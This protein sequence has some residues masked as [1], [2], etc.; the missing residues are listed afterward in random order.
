MSSNKKA[1]NKQQQSRSLLQDRTSVKTDNQQQTI[2]L[3]PSGNQTFEYEN[4]GKK[5][6]SRSNMSKKL[7]GSRVRNKQLSYENRSDDNGDNVILHS[8]NIDDEQIQIGQSTNDEF[9][10]IPPPG[11]SF[12]NRDIQR[13]QLS[14]K[15]AE[16][17]DINIVK[18]KKEKENF[19]AQ[20][21]LEQ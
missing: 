16:E 1:Y 3:V 2:T 7:S 13:D 8:V 10:H 4:K 12:N 19:K 14:I 21:K 20:K 15:I 18:Q 9:F 5:Q 11:A 6:S 17:L